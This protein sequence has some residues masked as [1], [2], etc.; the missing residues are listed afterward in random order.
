VSCLLSDLLFYVC[1]LGQLLADSHPMI[2]S[3]INPRL[4]FRQANSFSSYFILEFCTYP[5]HCILHNSITIN[6]EGYKLLLVFE[7]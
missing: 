6:G 3:Y 5:A 2:P 7:A 4:S 1:R